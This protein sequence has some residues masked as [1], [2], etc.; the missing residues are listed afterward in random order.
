MGYD[1]ERERG[2]VEMTVM[3]K[4]LP[5]ERL[6]CNVLDYSLP[7]NKSPKWFR[8]AIVTKEIQRIFVVGVDKMD[9]TATNTNQ[10]ILTTPVC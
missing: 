9:I 7:P 4:M 1:I 3:N 6:I 5:Y 10:I 2:Y 8:V